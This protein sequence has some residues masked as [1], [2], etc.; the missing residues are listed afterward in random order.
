MRSP[1]LTAALAILSA[2]GSSRVAVRPVGIGTYG[3]LRCVYLAEDAGVPLEGGGRVFPAPISEPYLPL[4]E[5]LFDGRRSLG[6]ASKLANRD[7]GLYDTLPWEWGRGERPKADAFARLAL[8]P[9]S[10]GGASAYHLLLAAITEACCAEVC[11]GYI[12]RASLLDDEEDAQLVIGATLSL[13]ESAELVSLY[14]ERVP[15][16]RDEPLRTADV[17]ATTDEMIGVAMAAGVPIEIE[18]DVWNAGAL[19]ARFTLDGGLMRVS[20][21]HPPPASDKQERQQQRAVAEPSKPLWKLTATEFRALKPAALAR[22]LLASGASSL[23]RPREATLERLSALAYPLL[24]ATVRNQLLLEEAVAAQNYAEAQRLVGAKS[25]RQLVAEALEA[26]LAEE[27]YARAEQLR[28]RL[29]V[30][31]E[32]RMD[33]TQEEGS[34]DR[35]LDQDEWYAEQQRR[36]YGPKNAGALGAGWRAGPRWARRAQPFTRTRPRMAGSGG[37]GWFDS[38]ADMFLGEQ[39]DIGDIADGAE[40]LQ[41]DAASSEVRDQ[42]QEALSADGFDGFALRDLLVEKW[43]KSYDVDFAVTQYLG[44]SSLYLNVFPWTIDREPFR[45]ES[46]ADYLEHLQ[47]VSELL[48]KWN[49]VA[50]VKQQIRETKKEPRR[51]TIPLKTVPLRLDLPDALVKSFQGAQKGDDYDSSRSSDD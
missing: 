10:S 13:R 31:T 17:E 23:P 6:G 15:M 47:A 19:P 9:S 39:L 35:F 44:R 37:R 25:Q 1:R 43:G 41:L 5:C 18:R 2:V 49:R 8:R 4:L 42:V 36:I 34:Y 51:G 26:A 3:G 22:A 28:A 40:K 48:V 16:P 38:I 33:P 30:L 29:D 21:D 20:I 24:D 45:H 50:L 11:C 7:G 12:E 27:D 14:G 46:E 32:L